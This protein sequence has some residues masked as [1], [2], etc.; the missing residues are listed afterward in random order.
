MPR[1]ATPCWCWPPSR[2]RSSSCWWWRARWSGRCGYCVMG[3]SRLLIPISTARSRRSAPATSR[4]PSHW[5]CTPPRKSVR[6]RMRSTS[7]TPGPCC[8]PARKRGCDCWSTRCLRPC[9]G[10]AVPW[11][12]S[13]CRSST[14]WSA[15]RRI[16]PDSTAFSG[17]ITWPPGC[18]ATAPTCWCW[19][20]RRLP[21]T[22]ASR[23]R[24]QP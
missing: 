11:S 10:V 24:C 16:P 6:S 19:P 7:C 13:S 17:S 8:W 9:R 3:R 22:T 1:F 5:R 2:P 21:V 15:T 23:C 20:V 4:S 14:N 18:A 12:T